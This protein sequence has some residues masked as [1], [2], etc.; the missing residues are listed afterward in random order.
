MEQALKADDKLRWL[1]P[2]GPRE[3]RA[4]EMLALLGEQI[5]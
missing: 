2:A 1:T 3:M 5:T 4:G